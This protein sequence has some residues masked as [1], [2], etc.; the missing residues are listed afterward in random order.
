M[1][2]GE[3]KTLLLRVVFQE[4]A[5]REYPDR[6]AHMSISG[7][8]V[9]ALL[10]SPY[11]KGCFGLADGWNL[12]SQYRED[13]TPFRR[14]IHRVLQIA[15]SRFVPAVLRGEDGRDM[16]VMLW[17]EGR[18]FIRCRHEARRKGLDP[19]PGGLE[20]WDG[21]RFPKAR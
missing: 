13:G 12:F 1:M 4:N 6:A 8:D 2:E 17:E 16:D 10:R 9:R 20:V 21:A 14:G 18:V 11:V 15:D 5:C 19:M 3:K 7:R